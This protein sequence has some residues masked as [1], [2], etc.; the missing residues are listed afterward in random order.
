MVVEPGYQRN[1]CGGAGNPQLNPAPV[2]THGIVA[3]D[4]ES[5]FF[6]IKK[7]RDNGVRNGNGDDVDTRQFHWHAACNLRLMNA[8]PRVLP[9][10]IPDA[11]AAAAGT[12][13]QLYPALKTDGG[14]ILCQF[15]ERGR[16]ESGPQ[17]GHDP[18]PQSG[19]SLP[20]SGNASPAAPLA[21]VPQAAL[22]QAAALLGTAATSSPGDAPAE[23]S[24]DPPSA[25]AVAL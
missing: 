2:G 17:T 5:Q 22:P 12:R 15:V 25:T 10:F 1:R 6:R 3:D 23:A 14:P 11:G 18:R 16:R 4:F 19:E 7:F 9:A 21:A 13:R 20:S 8:T 24:E